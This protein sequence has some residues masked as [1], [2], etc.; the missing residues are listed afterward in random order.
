MF[1]I[2]IDSE[3]GNIKTL[4]QAHDDFVYGL[5]THPTKDVFA[6][7]CD[8]KTVRV[9]DAQNQILAQCFP[10]Q[11]KAQCLS[12][13]PK[14]DLLAIGC[15]TGRF[16]VIE[17]DKRSL[18]AV[19]ELQER[20]EPILDIKFSPSGNLLAVASNE[21]KIDI[22]DCTSN[23]ARVSTCEGHTNFVTKLDW[24]ADDAYIRSTCCEYDLM[25]WETTKGTCM[26]NPKE[27][28]DVQW[29][30]E[31]CLLGWGV[32]GIWSK[33]SDGADI[34][35]VARGPNH[36]SCVTGS[37]NGAISLYRYPVVDEEQDHRSYSA[38]SSSVS[39]VCFDKDS[40]RVFSTGSLDMAI[41]QW[42]HQ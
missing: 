27:L 34:N 14:G 41:C 3:D 5:A 33:D 2:S 7:A 25:F 35:A 31:T 12:F 6:T 32:R 17:S 30:T 20:R 22:Y 29:A 1:E 42:R 18:V 40:K 15:T 24:S 10:M 39:N 36:E 19:K 37:D 21:N 28:R 4:V 23:Y 26:K 9:W 8:D 13:S 16:L 11:D 38:H